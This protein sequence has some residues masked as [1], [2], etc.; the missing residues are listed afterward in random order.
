MPFLK[1]IYNRDSE[2]SG[3]WM[4]DPAKRYA[5][6]TPAEKVRFCLEQAVVLS[7][8]EYLY[9]KEHMLLL[10][11]YRKHFESAYMHDISVLAEDKDSGEFVKPAYVA[12]EILLG[13]IPGK[14]DS[15]EVIK[16]LKPGNIDCPKAVEPSFYEPYLKFKEYV[17]DL[18]QYV[19]SEQMRNTRSFTIAHPCTIPSF[20]I[21]GRF[22]SVNYQMEFSSYSFDYKDVKDIIEDMAEVDTIFTYLAGYHWSGKNTTSVFGVLA[23]QC[24]TYD[25][26]DI[27]WDSVMLGCIDAYKKCINPNFYMPGY[28]QALS[29]AVR[30]QRRKIVRFLIYLRKHQRIVFEDDQILADYADSI[31]SEDGHSLKD[32]FLSQREDISAEVYSVFRNSRFAQFEELDKFRKGYRDAAGDKKDD[33]KQNGSDDAEKSKGNTKDTAPKSENSDTADELRGM[34]SPTGVQDPKGDDTK[35]EPDADT[36]PDAEQNSDPKEGDQNTENPDE[37]NPEDE[38]SENEPPPLPRVSD[39][40]GMELKLSEGESPDTVLYREEL[41]VYIDAIL[42][43]PPSNLSVQT[44]AAIK[45]LK[46]NWLYLLDVEC[47]YKFMSALIKVPKSLK[48]KP[49]KKEDK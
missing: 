38:N 20:K 36:N 2:V 39:R 13:H 18:R 1:F 11:E 34:E 24:L 12:C 48:V 37:E 17:S 9:G 29:T 15:A 35:Q 47:L 44:I 41:R 33:G 7:Y 40:K 22:I 32:Y 10:S 8:L 49:P 30:T 6:A 23:S 14:I 19:E 16:Y 43:N 3:D 31:S 26:G 27:G 28:L 25:I 45:R 46:S 42:K 4:R 5:M 21:D